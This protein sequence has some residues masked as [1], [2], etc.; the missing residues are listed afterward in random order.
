MLLAVAVFALCIIGF[1]LSRSFSLSV[2][3]L[4]ASGVADNDALDDGVNAAA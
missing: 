4:F 2:V 1:G 3:L